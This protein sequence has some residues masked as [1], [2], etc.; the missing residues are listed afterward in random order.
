MNLSKHAAYFI[1]K[2]AALTRM[3][4]SQHSQSEVCKNVKWLLNFSLKNLGLKIFGKVNG[5]MPNTGPQRLPFTVKVFRRIRLG[6]TCLPPHQKVLGKE[7]QRRQKVPGL[8]SS[9]SQSTR[10]AEAYLLNILDP[11]HHLERQRECQ[12]S[13]F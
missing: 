7:T 10:G 13:P 8:C 1:G 6:V 5:Q 2:Q 11:L 12:K 9:P 4:C 3:L